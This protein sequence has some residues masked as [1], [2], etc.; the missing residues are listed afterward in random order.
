MTPKWQRARIVKALCPQEQCFVGMEV[1]T[2]CGSKDRI[3]CVSSL[4]ATTR[5]ETRDSIQANIAFDEAD[6]VVFGRF[7]CEILELLARDESDFA[8]DVPLIPWEQFLAECRGAS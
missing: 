6:R 4:D 8:E 7:D 2:R 3:E 1:W 5:A